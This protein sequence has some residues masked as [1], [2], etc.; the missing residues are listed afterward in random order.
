MGSLKSVTCSACHPI[1]PPIQGTIWAHP[2]CPGHDRG[3]ERI[4]VKAN[5]AALTKILPGKEDRFG[6]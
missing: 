5:Q 2:I 4:N 3:T 6:K 1:I